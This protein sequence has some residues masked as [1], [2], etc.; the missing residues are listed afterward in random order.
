[1]QYLF[2]FLRHLEGLATPTCSPATR[3]A[4][5]QQSN[6]ESAAGQQE[7]AGDQLRSWSEYQF[8]GELLL[9]ELSFAHQGF[10]IASESALRNVFQ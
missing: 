5:F 9:K 6:G 8:F 4:C 3:T 7:E 1:M 10:R 2:L